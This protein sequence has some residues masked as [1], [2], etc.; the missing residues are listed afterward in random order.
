MPGTASDHGYDVSIVLNLHNEARY[1][2]RT[3]CSLEEAVRF[4]RRYHITFELV[5]VLDRP[6]AATKAWIDGYD[7]SVFDGH[8]VTVVDNG[9]FGPSRNDGVR[10]AHGEYVATADGDD[11]VSY[12]IFASS[13]LT[14]RSS[15]RRSIVMAQY[16]YA[17]GDESR[18]VQYFDSDKVNR[19]GF[20]SYHPYISRVFVHSA[21]FREISYRDG[22][23]SSGFACDDW[24][25]TCD[26]LALGYHFIVADNTVLFYRQRPES[27]L[28]NANNRAVKVTGWSRYHEPTTFV[29]VC[30]YDFQKFRQRVPPP[31]HGEI[32]RAFAANLVCQEMLAAANKI[33]PAIDPA[34]VSHLETFSNLDGFLDYGAAYYQLCLLIGR[35]NFTDVVLLPFLATG[36]ADKYILDLLNALAKLDPGRR[37]LVLTG[38]ALVR[39]AWTDRLPPNSL[40]I[41]LYRACDGCPNDAVELMALRLIQSMG[42]TVRIYVKSS[43]FTARFFRRFDHVLQCAAVVYF[44]FSDPIVYLGG[45]PAFRGFNFD[46]LSA[47]QAKLTHVVTDHSLIASHD[48]A[49]LDLL[50]PRIATIYAKCGLLQNQSPPKQRRSHGRLLWASRLDSEKRPALAIQIGKA[51]A[52]I[53]PKVSIDVYGSA[54]MDTFDVKQFRKCGNITYKGSFSGFETLAHE[55]YDAFL[56]TS[57]Y[58]GLPNVILEAMAAGLPVIAPDVGGI[59]EAVNKDTGFLVENSPDDSVLVERYIAAISA[60]YDPL[61]DVEARRRAALKVIEERHSE[62][63]YLKRVAEIFRLPL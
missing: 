5:A 61:T 11:L 22:R 33:D 32:R 41:D 27:L 18:L 59:S 14:A 42:P 1:L 31:P 55:N 7:F 53:F 8:E 25:F 34:Q 10:I 58:D 28:R 56:Y 9:S 23:L 3:L 16:L 4:A 13:Y 45:R 62:Q 15:D 63:T 40:F 57:A 52:K 20:F 30:A 17:F 6:D 35:Q 54:V 46:F 47:H 39:H 51:V 29:K 26:A 43:V 2:R 24:H 49:R 60:L 19:L 38:E 44:R 21:I 12:N 48:C 36:G 37:F 50:A